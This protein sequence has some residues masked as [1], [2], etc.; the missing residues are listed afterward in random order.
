LH[1]KIGMMRVVSDT[2][3]RSNLAYLY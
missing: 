3:H 2:C 1:P